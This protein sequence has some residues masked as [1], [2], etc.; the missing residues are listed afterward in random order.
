M[1]ILINLISFLTILSYCYYRSVD[2][3]PLRGHL[4]P[5]CT[6]PELPISPL[7]LRPRLLTRSIEKGN[8]WSLYAFVL[9]ILKLF[10]NVHTIVVYFFLV[11]ELGTQDQKHLCSLQ[12]SNY[13]AILDNFTVPVCIFPMFNNKWLIIKLTCAI[14]NYKLS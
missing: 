1:Y 14:W 11:P 7:F 13:F 5:N 12:L 9:F 2:C 3:W 6:L 4:V 10:Y 8:S